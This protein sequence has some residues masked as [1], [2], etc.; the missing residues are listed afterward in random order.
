MASGQHRITREA[1]LLWMSRLEPERSESAQAKE[2]AAL[3]EQAV[4]GNSA[5]FEQI[6]ILTQRRVLNLAWKLLGSLAEAQDA[7]QEVFMRAY[8]YLHRFDT[9]KPFEPWLIRITVNVCRDMMRSR[10]QSRN[11]FAET[12]LSP[13]PAEIASAGDPHSMLAAEQQKEI[14]R[15][16]LS[17]LPEKERTALVLRD[18]EG[19]PTSEVAAILKSSA[20]TV[21]SQISSARLK[22]KKALKGVRP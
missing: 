6:L 1:A 3:M 19:L 15:K 22:I 13:E 4:A 21:R 5:A 2:L 7:A 10:Q 9:R 18:I 16:A 14:L 8:K 12:E 11:L 17:R 20:A